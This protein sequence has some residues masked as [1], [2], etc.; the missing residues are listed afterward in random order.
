MNHEERRTLERQ[1]RHVGLSRTQAKAAV[2][3]TV[4][5]L[6]EAKTARKEKA[7]QPE[8]ERT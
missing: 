1:L 5:V 7:G 2:A 6:A 3:V 8:Q 4:R